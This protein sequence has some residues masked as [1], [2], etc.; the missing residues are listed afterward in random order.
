MKSIDFFD[1]NSFFINL[2]FFNLEIIIFL[3]FILIISNTAYSQ[4]DTNQKNKRALIIAIGGYPKSSEWESLSSVNDIELIKSTLLINQ[5]KD[6]NIQ[7]ISDSLATKQNIVDAIIQI[8]KISME[9]DIIVIH[10]SG[11]GQQI[12]DNNNFDEIDGYDESLIPYDAKPVYNKDYKGENHLRDDEILVL[13]NKIRKRIGSNGEL[14]VIL[15]ACHSGTATRGFSKRRG[16]EIKLESLEYKNNN[17]KIKQEGFEFFSMSSDQ[18]DNYAPVIVISGANQEESNYEYHD[19]NSNKNYGSLS[20]AFSEVMSDIKPN[21][22]YQSL[23]EKIKAKMNAMVPHQN[24]QIEGNTNQ[25]VFLGK[26]VSQQKYYKIE[27]WVNDTIVSIKAGNL[28]GIYNGT[29]MGFYPENIRN[30]NETKFLFK[31]VVRNARA[32]ESDIVLSQTIK[33]GEFANSFVFVE[34]QTFG[35]LQLTVK[36]DEKLNDEFKSQLSQKLNEQ[37]AIRLVDK[38]AEMIVGHF[39]EEEECLIQVITQDDIE[40]LKLSSNDLSTKKN[41]NKVSKTLRNFLQAK[42]L[43]SL[44]ISNEDLN[45]SFEI[46]PVNVKYNNSRYEI[47]NKLNINDFYQKG[48]NLYFNN[49]QAFKIK[50]KNDGCMKAF[51]HVLDIQADNSVCILIPSVNRDE[52]EYSI[53]PGEEKELPELF[54]FGP[55]FGKEC[56]KLIA[57]KSSI[58]LKSIETKRGINDNR[59]YYSPIEEFFKESYRQTRNGTISIPPESIHTYELIINVVNN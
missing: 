34:K 38:N 2:R 8:E 46:V 45:V 6:E 32:L 59:V 17:N 53:Y 47:T 26:P 23:F 36:I 16:T 35:G 28:V 19:I 40:L 4:Q 41:V 24:P 21:T 7:I 51:I 25:L 57:T 3:F 13:L 48:G 18:E 20:F 52:T 22:T 1:K 43:M 37:I 50:V 56:L 5:F 42:L 33:K 31:G 10:F 58:N 27:K 49:Q 9:G 29:E 39:D 55:P 12:M 15:D 54:L 14:L 44:D 30:K 11:H